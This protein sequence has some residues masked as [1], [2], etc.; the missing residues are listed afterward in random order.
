LEKGPLPLEQA[1]KLGTQIA[2]ALDTAHHSAV[3]HR[4]PKPGKTP[5][6]RFGQGVGT[7]CYWSDTDRLGEAITSD[8]RGNCG[9]HFPIHV[10]GAGGRQGTGWTQ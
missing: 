8:R 5:R 9:R 4:D 10:A 2:D 3:V 7:C 1:L 6:L